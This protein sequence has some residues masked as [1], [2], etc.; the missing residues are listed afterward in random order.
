MLMNPTLNIPQARFLTMP[1]KFKAYVAGFGSGKTWAGCAAICKHFWEHPKINQGYFAPTYPQIRD[2]FYPTIE[3][4]AFDWGLKLRLNESNKEVH[5]YSGRQ[6]RGTTI[7]R[8]MEKPSTIVGFKIGNGLVDEMDVM[9]AEKAQ[10]AWRK[11]IARMRYNVDGLLNGISVTTTPE[12]FK[13]VWQQFVKEVRDKPELATLYGLIHAST[14]DNEKNLPAD[15]I[16]SLLASYPGPLIT[17]YL[18]G[19]FTNL[20][21]GTIYHQ[22]DR[23][24]NNCEDLEQPGEPLYIGMDFNVGKMAGI[25]HV[26][27]DGQ[28]RAVTEIINAYD[29]P[30]IIRIIKE[31]F[32]FYDGNNYRKVREIYIYPDASGDSRKSSNASTTDIAQLKQ[33]GF[34][35]VVNDANPPVKDRINSVNAMFCNSKGERRYLVNVKR[36]PVYTECLEQQVW[37]EKTGEPDKK[38]GKDHANDGGGYYII[39]QFPIIK[40]QGKVT[41]LRM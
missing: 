19:R 17:A 22:F 7:C 12:G 3:E 34:N 13:F 29:T 28:P 41:K 25:V 11:I 35:V 37:D 26:L 15:Y 9:K 24:K 16:P 21:S 5:F 31:R 40:P 38:S 33:A 30:D 10:I 4:V 36:C 23:R 8:S 2:I 27:R 20:V 39:K 1:H 14:Y 6:Y 18:R 32:W